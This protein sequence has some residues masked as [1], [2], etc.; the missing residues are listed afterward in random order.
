MDMLA[1][2]M[3]S[4]AM[5]DLVAAR[6][7]ESADPSSSPLLQAPNWAIEMFVAGALEIQVGTVDAPP[8]PWRR[9]GVG[10]GVIYAPGTRYRERLAVGERLCRSVFAYV[11][12][13]PVIIATGGALAREHTWIADRGRLL[14]G[15]LTTVAEQ[16]LGGVAEVLRASAGV[17]ETLAWIVA[18]RLEVDRLHIGA[19]VGRESD[20]LTRVHRYF[21]DH[22]ADPIRLSDVA[23]HVGVS[24]SG[25]SH[26]Y[27]RF[28]GRSPM[29]TLQQFRLD[30]AMHEL[31]R[32]H[33][34]LET[35]ARRYGFADAF[36]LSRAFKR[37]FGA[38]PRHWL[39]GQQDL[40][41]VKADSYP[42]T[43]ALDSPH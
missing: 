10:E 1:N 30:A 41:H 29:Q 9:C 36:H 2:N 38:S 39:A 15:L 12:L 11:K 37:R 20:L 33:D 40:P 13:A 25:L 6:W 23:R 17:H 14:S 4:P 16:H 5:V 22:L 34:K 21:L 26:T 18:G 31:R 35:I 7:F 32:R 43:R 42:Q 19:E 27:R 24:D 28:A 3:N 8:T